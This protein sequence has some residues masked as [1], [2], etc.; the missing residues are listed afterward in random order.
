MRD[1]PFPAFGIDQIGN[2]EDR[3]SPRHHTLQC[4]SLGAHM[5]HHRLQ[6]RVLDIRVD[7][8]VQV[9]VRAV[10]C[11]Y[12]RA[13]DA[14]LGGDG[15]CAERLDLPRPNQRIDSQSDFGR[16]RHTFL[17]TQL[18]ENLVDLL[19][20]CVRVGIDH[21]THAQRITQVGFTL[22]GGV[23][24]DLAGVTAAAYGLLQLQQRGCLQSQ[25][26]SDSAVA[27]VSQWG[28]LDSVAMQRLTLWS[29]FGEALLE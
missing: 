18:L 8:A 29:E 19:H 21:H 5:A 10:C 27:Q 3:L 24:Y 20:F 22:A 14:K 28:G 6:P 16:G 7:D 12:P 1:T 9:R 11:C 23:K 25:T 26:A 4:H 15:R 13:G 17:G 2:V